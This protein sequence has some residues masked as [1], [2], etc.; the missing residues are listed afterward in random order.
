VAGFIRRFVF[1]RDDVIYDLVAAWIIT[2]YLK[3]LFEYV[4]YLFAHSPEPQ[5]GKSRLL[6]ILDLLVMDSSGVLVSPTE[7]VIFRTANETQLLDEVDAWGNKDA[8]KSVLNAGFRAG[9]AV[10]RME[11]RK[12]EGYRKVRFPVYGPRA[13]AGIGTKILDVTTRDRTFML[14][15]VRQTKTER[16]QRLRMRAVK[17]EAECLKG[18][19]VEWAKANKAAI[20]DVYDKSKFPYLDHLRDRT[21]DITQ[22]LASVIEVAYSGKAINRARTRLV[23]A[24]SIT[25]TEE[26]SPKD[27]HKVLKQLLQV[28]EAEDPL[29]GTAIELNGICANLQD[30]PSQ[31]AITST[32]RTYGFETK[33]C[34]KDG[35]EPRYRYV[36]HKAKLE[37]IL[38]RYGAEGEI[39]PAEPAAEQAEPMLAEEI[40]EADQAI[41]DV[42]EGP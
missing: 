35:G 36:L 3:D 9:G 7:A 40:P 41:E 17:P 2:T 24:V 22:P 15:M 31:E 16:R 26:H 11:E 34:R 28:P 10:V 33:S 38:V 25:R 27:Q 19:I 37:E 20:A 4:G 6:E 8:L 29:V 32:L 5:S 21:I 39:Q 1:F 14:E 18:R 23:R 30:P 12:E 13:L 42:E